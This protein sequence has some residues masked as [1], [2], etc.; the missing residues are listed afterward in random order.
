MPPHRTLPQELVDQVIDELGDAYRDP[1][2]DKRPD[3]RIVACEALHACAL[4][5]KNW[6]N[7]SRVHLFRDAKIR[8]DEDGLCL[9]PPQSLMPYVTRLKILLWCQYYR[10]FPSRD[11]LTPFYT[12]PVA[13]LRITGGVLA[14]EAKVCLVECIAALSASLQTL[15]FKSCSLS[16][17][18]ITDILVAHPSLKRLHLLHC[19]VKPVKSDHSVIPPLGMCSEAPDLE[20]G[21]FSQP[22][23][24]G[25][26][27]AIAAVAQL[28][29]YF[30]R[31]DFYHLHNPGVIHATNALIKTNAKSL[32]SLTVHIISGTS[33]ILN[34]Y[35]T[36]NC[37]RN[38]EG[39]QPPFSLEGCFNLSE[40]TLD[41]SRANS[42][43]V[44]TSFDIISTLDPIQ[45][46]RLEWIKLTTSCVYQ[47]T[48]VGSRTALAQTWGNLD[49]VPSGLAKVAI[50][51]RRKRLTFVLVS[52]GTH[53]EECISFERKWLPELLPRFHELGSS[54]V[55]YGRGRLTLAADYDCFCCHVT[56]CMGKDFNDPSR[57]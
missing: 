42:C 57:G 22:M 29:K 43:I 21:D 38:I 37:Y 14:T 40:L 44:T 56:T 51:M 41:M 9:I 15:V 50:S 13:Y 16:L 31:L 12:A 2:H 53:K 49:T 54:R 26:D 48:R 17:H 4:V 5:S 10:L 47:R 20:L 7:R 46:S 19:D 33:G 34:H 36:T 27:L 39:G 24:G 28:P 30:G 11:L 8:G 45:R 18:L 6:T 52:T 23:W 35:H 1:D 32:S 55:D 3:H 25:H